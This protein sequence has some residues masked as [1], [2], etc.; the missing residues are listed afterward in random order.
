M[1]INQCYKKDGEEIPIKQN[2]KKTDF[3][4]LKELLKKNKTEIDYKKSE[5]L[6]WLT[7]FDQ[8]SQMFFGWKTNLKYGIM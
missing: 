8:N 3:P 5:I 1:Y 4:K 7:L 2:F 6:A